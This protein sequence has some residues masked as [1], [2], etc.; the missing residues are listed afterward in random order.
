MTDNNTD[1]NQKSAGE[2]TLMEKEKKEKGANVETQADEWAA[3][4]SPKASGDEEK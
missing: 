3:K 2:D 4:P 1:P